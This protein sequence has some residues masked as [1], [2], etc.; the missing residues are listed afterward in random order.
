MVRIINFLI[1]IIRLLGGRDMIKLINITTGTK[2]K[3]P[4]HGREEYSLCW[5]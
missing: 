2:L 1:K 4:F 5:P 3:V